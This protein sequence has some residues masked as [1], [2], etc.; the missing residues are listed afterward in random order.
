MIALLRIYLSEYAVLSYNILF[1]FICDYESIGYLNYY[2]VNYFSIPP[3]K[4]N[5]SMD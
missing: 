1:T 5:D 2:H 3:I 4:L